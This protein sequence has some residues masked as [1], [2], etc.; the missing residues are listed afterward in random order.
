ML[1]D[2]PSATLQVTLPERCQAAPVVLFERFPGAD[3]GL[4][5]E[6][7]ATGEV[8]GLATD[9]PT[10]FL[11]AAM[12]AGVDLASAVRRGVLVFLDDR[13]DGTGVEVAARLAETGVPLYATRGIRDALERLGIRARLVH[14]GGEGKPDAMDLIRGG[15]VGLVI[16]TPLGRMSSLDG[17]A[18]RRAALAAGVPCLTT[19][20]GASYA[21]EAVRTAAA[22]P[23]VR[24]LQAWMAGGP[25]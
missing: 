17:F 24:S 14:K 8:I 23:E 12:G 9:G 5:P 6:M 15:E 4:G 1:R 10:A 16:N 20:S 25:G 19:L 2:P 21:I 7:L 3:P 13:D 11:K 18:L 22:R